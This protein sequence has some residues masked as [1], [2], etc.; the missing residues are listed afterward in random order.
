MRELMLVEGSGGPEK[1]LYLR[2]SS[3]PVTRTESFASGEVNVDLDAQN[4][5]IGIEMLSTDPEELE[6]L[7]RLMRSHD[8][9][10]TGLFTGNVKRAS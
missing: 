5:V 3:T 8:L 4:Q 7:A 10:L 9:R 1:P 2:F 6:V